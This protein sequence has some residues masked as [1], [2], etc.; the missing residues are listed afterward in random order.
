MKIGTFSCWLF[1]HKFLYPASEFVDGHDN[2]LRKWVEATDFCVRC[3][4][5]RSDND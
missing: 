1:G 2:Y 4:I 5:A 3:G